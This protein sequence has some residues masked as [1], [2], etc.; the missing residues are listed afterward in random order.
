MRTQSSPLQWQEYET[1]RRAYAREVLLSRDPAA[2]LFSNPGEYQWHTTLVRAQILRRWELHGDVH[3]LF[4]DPHRRHLVE[5]TAAQQRLS[6]MLERSS[7]SA[8]RQYA[9]RMGIYDDLRAEE[10]RDPYGAMARVRKRLVSARLS[11]ASVCRCFLEEVCDRAFGARWQGDAS[12][13]AALSVALRED[14]RLAILPEV[15]FKGQDA[16]L[17]GAF[18]VQFFVRQGL[19]AQDEEPFPHDQDIVFYRLALP[20]GFSVYSS[21]YSDTELWLACAAWIEAVVLTLRHLSGKG[22]AATLS[23]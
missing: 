10:L 16:E 8:R 14:L 20:D 5:L 23:A 12:A 18:V 4:A 17:N 15:D 13:P 6:E 21:F 22:W 9:I 2:I 7:P 3:A 1:F 11:P 19:P